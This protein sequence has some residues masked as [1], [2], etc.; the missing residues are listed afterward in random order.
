MSPRFVWRALLEGFSRNDLL[1]YASA[2]SFQILTAIIPFLLFV[3]AAAGLLNLGYVWED[4]LAPEI[5]AQVSREVFTVLSDAVDQVFDGNQV[6]WVTFGGALAL[7]QVSGAVRAVMG[8]FDGIY[9]AQERAFVRRYAVSF[10]LSIAVGACFILAALCLF[11]APFFDTSDL[12]AG[13]GVVTFIGRWTLGIACLALAVGLLVHVAPA[14]PQP[15]P[16]VSLGTAI[17]IVTWVVVSLA[18]YV[19]LT[20][21]A[22]YDSVFGS[23]ASIIVLM[24]YLYLSTVVFL[25]GAQLDAIIRTNASG[26]P[27]GGP[28]A[29]NVSP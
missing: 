27:N 8:A 25:F 28:A 7:W 29:G 15:L 22:A 14:V 18:F 16:W 10:A 24:G 9:G 11:F 3:L 17:V 6:A 26:K 20:A 12:G 4:H 23:L 19:Y 1:T 5:Q 2:I 13:W 21:I